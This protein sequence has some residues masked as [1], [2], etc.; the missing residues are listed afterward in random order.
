MLSACT[1][2]L[3]L[4]G[5]TRESEELE[6]EFSAATGTDLKQRLR[7]GALKL[8]DATRLRIGERLR[9]VAVSL[10]MEVDFATAQG[11]ASGCGRTVCML[12]DG[13][14]EKALTSLNVRAKKPIIPEET[15]AGSY[16][17]ILEDLELPEDD[18]IT[19][20][21][22]DA[23]MAE[24]EAQREAAN[25]A[26][27][28]STDGD[29]ARCMINAEVNAEAWRAEADRLAPELSRIS[30]KGSA[31]KFGAW[32]TRLLRARECRDT[33]EKAGPEACMGAS[34]WAEAL[35]ADVEKLS[36]REAFVNREWG[37]QAA[38]YAAARERL[39]L[40]ISARERA[41]ESVSEL[42][43]H[44]AELSAKVQATAEAIEERQADFDGARPLERIKG[45]L[46]A[47]QV[48]TKDMNRRVEILR[49]EL[50]GK[51]KR[52]AEE[53]RRAVGRR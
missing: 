5:R 48:E 53:T 7:S 9:S 35:R 46:T 30:V 22:Y 47:L 24:L 42:T 3:Q 41:E 6:K 13:L 36:Q 40:V 43:S 37:G 38:E 2:L 32:E 28:R 4:N 51:Q 34:A 15:E 16:G 26:A 31:G 12:L 45:A 39:A 33:F 10:D 44:L 8:D 50:L 20:E 29:A 17:E 19:G 23:S 27:L 18:V 25:A 14:A 11:V 21:A 49:G 1:W 52:L